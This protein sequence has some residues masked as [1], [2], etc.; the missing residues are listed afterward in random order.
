MKKRKV[1]CP[2]PTSRDVKGRNAL[3]TLVKGTF[4]RILLLS[5]FVPY[6]M[7]CIEPPRNGK[8]DEG[9]G[10]LSCNTSAEGGRKERK[11]R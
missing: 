7:E 5:N 1:L 9:G 10:R 8:G 6:V 2:T 3:G 11:T 4:P